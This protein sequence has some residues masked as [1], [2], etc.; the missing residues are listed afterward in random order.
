MKVTA[1]RKFNLK[2][3]DSHKSFYGKAK[4]TETQDGQGNNFAILTSYETVV[5]VIDDYDNEDFRE[6]YRT[7]GGYSATTM[8]HINS[9]RAIYG[10]SP[11]NKATWMAMPRVY[12]KY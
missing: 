3:M 11:I 7:W 2:P 5:A 9:F 12:N 6:F 8:R 10:L 1:T 4:V